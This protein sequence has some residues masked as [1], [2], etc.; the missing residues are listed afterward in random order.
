MKYYIVDAFTQEPFHGNPAGVCLLEEWPERD[1]LQ[2]IAAENNLPETAF[3]KPAGGYYELKWFTPE[4]EIDLCGHGTLAS[5][6]VLFRFVKPEA[7]TIRFRTMS[8]ELTVERRGERLEMDFPARP[9][10]AVPIPEG[11]ENA[12]GAKVLETH[13]S[14]DLV[15]LLENEETVRNLRPDMEALERL[16]LGH[17]AVV[18]AKGESAD[19][20]SRFFT[21]GA[22]IPEDPVT[23]SSHST[24]IPFWSARLG[25]NQMTA[26]QLSKRGGTLFCEN[27]GE[28]VGI[29]GNAVLYLEGEIRL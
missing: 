13:R 18:T 4:T 24:L 17:A 11:L 16:Q 10:E 7:K 2:S 29:A 14:R 15:A 20:V 23:G 9:P 1:R 5:A 12:L 22:G 21:P 19:F 25:K 28:R 3:L 6:F 8:G 26:K 27:R